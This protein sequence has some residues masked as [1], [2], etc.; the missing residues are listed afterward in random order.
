MFLQRTMIIYHGGVCSKYYCLA[1]F[2]YQRQRQHT[3][4]TLQGCLAT[5]TWSRLAR[6]CFSRSLRFSAFL[7]AP[8]F[9]LGISASP[10]R[11]QRRR[12]CFVSVKRRTLNAIS[13]CCTCVGWFI[14]YESTHLNKKLY[15]ECYVRQGEHIHV[16]VFPLCTPQPKQWKMA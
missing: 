5:S 13:L 2:H 1:F 14:W 4:L 6:I 8:V 11:Y 16:K 9:F 10:G 15:F 3:M 12:N 7:R